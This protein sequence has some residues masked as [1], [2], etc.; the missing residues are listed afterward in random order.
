M[1]PPPTRAETEEHSWH[2]GTALPE[3]ISALIGS[4]PLRGG[5][6]NLTW[7][8][9]PRSPFLYR[10]QHKYGLALHDQVDQLSTNRSSLRGNT[11]AR[12]TA[13]I[14][15]HLKHAAHIGRQSG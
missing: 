11:L 1:R 13:T 9:L 8:T 4:D 7:A 5:R 10:G 12:N 3:A 6:A 15:Q 14:L 2:S